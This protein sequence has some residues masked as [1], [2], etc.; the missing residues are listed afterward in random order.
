MKKKISPIKTVKENNE[1]GKPTK[2]ILTEDQIRR[3]IERLKNE[4]L[5]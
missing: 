4:I 2:V 1:K 5:Q 3:L